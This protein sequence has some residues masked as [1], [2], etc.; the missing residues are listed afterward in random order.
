M[1]DG[2]GAVMKMGFL[3]TQV[4]MLAIAAFNLGR[5]SVEF[6]GDTLAWTGLV[7]WLIVVPASL[8]ALISRFMRSDA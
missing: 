4:L 8:V 6:S 1:M 3:L 7:C 2:P 5:Y